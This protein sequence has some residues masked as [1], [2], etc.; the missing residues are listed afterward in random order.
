MIAS[1]ALGIV[2]GCS[3]REKSRSSDGPDRPKI[4]V[5]SLLNCNKLVKHVRPIYPAEAKEKGI[6]GAVRLSAVITESGSVRV[7]EILEGS[8]LLV[9]PAITA[10]ERWKY[11]PC[12]ID[13]KPVEVKTIL[14]ISF[15]P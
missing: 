14:E 12:L 8:P 15:S 9:P 2:L 1:I 11:T 3:P 10:A 6:Q 7:L 13:A 5:R 4:V